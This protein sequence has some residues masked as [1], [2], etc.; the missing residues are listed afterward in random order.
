MEESNKLQRRKPYPALKELN[1]KEQRAI[2]M[3]W[4]G[5]TAKEIATECGYANESH[6]RGLFIT[7][8]RLR[9]ALEEFK[10]KQIPVEDRV[11]EAVVLAKKQ[12]VDC[13]EKLIEL[14][15]SGDDAKMVKAVEKLL[16][17]IGVGTEATLLNYF[18]GKPFETARRVVNE[19]FRT[20]YGQALDGQHFTEMGKI[21][22]T[23]D[24]VEKELEFNVG[25]ETYMPP[26][27]EEKEREL[28]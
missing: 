23:I 8:G 12:A 4:Q 27:Q 18:R 28:P 16:P 11:T 7:K 25:G 15:D 6:V 1:D 3:K 17:I 10:S 13:I 2:T 21:T 22:R 19:L 14:K 5:K 24:G 9:P 26:E 20:L